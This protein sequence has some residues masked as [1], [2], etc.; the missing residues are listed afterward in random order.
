MTAV[1]TGQTGTS[2]P[3]A[4]LALHVDGYELTGLKLALSE[5]FTRL[6]TS[7]RSTAPVTAG[8]G[9]IPPTR[10]LPSSRPAA[11]APCCPSPATGR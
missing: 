10:R 11:P 2:G 8:S 5:R 9:R 6:S 1:E 3:L 7:S 4:D